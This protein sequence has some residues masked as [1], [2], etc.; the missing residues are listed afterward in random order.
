MPQTFFNIFI[1]FLNLYVSKKKQE[2]A[3]ITNNVGKL[4]MIMTEFA[5]Y[6]LSEKM[7]VF[8]PDKLIKN[9]FY[10][11]IEGVLFFYSTEPNV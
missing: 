5:N 10:W 7:Q 2:D 11:E 9:N 3:V 4:S 8:P 1:G 6:G